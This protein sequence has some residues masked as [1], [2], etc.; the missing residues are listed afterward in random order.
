MASYIED[1]TSQSKGWIFD[2]GSTVHVCSQK[3]LLHSLV[4]KKNEI[5]KN[6]KK[7]R[8]KKTGDIENQRYWDDMDDVEE[9]NIINQ[10]EC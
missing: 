1:N 5:V 9:H 2:S 7:L 4:A 3:E 10:M 8:G 6:W